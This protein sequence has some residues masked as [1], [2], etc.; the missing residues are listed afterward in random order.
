[1]TT[2]F[3][4][5]R[6]TGSRWFLLLHLL[7]VSCISPKEELKARTI[8]AEEI[9]AMLNKNQPVIIRDCT[10]TGD[11]D[12][13]K[14]GQA[15]PLNPGVKQ[16]RV[17]APVYFEGCHFTGAVTGVN[18]A[19]GN[20]QITCFPHPVS[21]YRCQ[22]DGG[23]DFSGAVFE[24]QLN[25][26]KSYFEQPV[27]LQAT[28]ITGDFR[29]EEAVFSDDF[30]MQESVVRG[31]FWGKDA[32]LMG[33]FSAQQAD[34]WQHVVLTGISVHG[35][36]DMSLVNFR[37]SAFFGYGKYYERV[38]YNGARFWERAEWTNALYTRT[39]NLDAARFSDVTES[40]GLEVR[41]GMS[42]NGARFEQ[43]RP[44]EFKATSP[45]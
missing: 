14:A 45:E 18:P 26:T 12:F 24:N 42:V 15:I 2:P 27:T 30:L 21:F 35:Y 23:F 7:A 6:L 22:V 3:K 34:F 17:G 32:T 4:S 29:F 41:E 19:A 11:L 8:R 16:V 39:V 13:T 20:T 38:V 33:Q 1:M 43:G 36:T 9:L 37:R 44:E 25:L 28:R 5:P 40:V 10:V 31:T